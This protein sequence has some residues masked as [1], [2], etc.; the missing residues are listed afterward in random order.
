MIPVLC[1]LSGCA[2]KLLGESGSDDSVA[3]ACGEPESAPRDTSL[4][5]WS[6]H[7]EEDGPDKWGDLPG[8]EECGAGTTQ[9]PIDIPTAAAVPDSRALSFEDYD[10][11]LPLNLLNNGH[12]LE[13]ELESSTDV[14]GPRISYDGGEPYT[15]AQ[16]H[17]H[18]DSEH[19]LDETGAL[20]ELHFV[21]KD[22]AG[23]IAVVGVLLDEGDENPIIETLL[24]VDPGAYM[25]V[26]CDTTVSP[27]DLVPTS[28]GF[29]AYDGSL[30]TPKCTRGLKWF[31][32]TE[33]GTVSEDQAERWKEK[34]HG[35]TNRPVQALNGRE[36]TVYSPGG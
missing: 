22:A 35:T 27:A 23:N 19:T 31:V 15:L 10:A 32:M 1:L 14:L 6:Y 17:G 7:G 29:Y 3:S 13:V 9:S 2:D 34:F 28:S 25:R 20:M 12:S 4:P 11:A 30:T 16:F 36:V 24:T 18:A 33:H 21:H 8:Y 5:E 26:S